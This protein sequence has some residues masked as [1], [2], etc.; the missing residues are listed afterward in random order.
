VKNRTPQ[1]QRRGSDAVLSEKQKDPEAFN[2]YCLGKH[3]PLVAKLP[4]LKRTEVATILPAPPDQPEPPYWR[5]TELYFD[6]AEDLR[7]GFATEEGKAAGAD[8]ANF[9]DKGTVTIFASRI[10]A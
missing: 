7:K 1:K 6:S 4:G 3:M 10:Q 5:I 2:K 8:L 9:T